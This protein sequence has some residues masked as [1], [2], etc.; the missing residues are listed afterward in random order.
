LKKVWILGGGIASVEAAISLR[1]EGF[2]VSLVS[3]R[4]FVFIRPISIWIP[5]RKK[6]FEDVCLSLDEL[7]N[8]H[9]F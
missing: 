6:E 2:E 4:D 3:N 7:A 8:M 5:T 9:G 1:Q